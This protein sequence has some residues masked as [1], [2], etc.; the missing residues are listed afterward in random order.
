MKSKK[1]A[2][3]PGRITRPDQAWAAAY[4]EKA[5]REVSTPEASDSPVAIGTALATVDEA[6]RALAAPSVLSIDAPRRE[7]PGLALPLKF[8]TAALITAAS[9]DIRYYLNGV[10]IHAADGEMR[11][12]G[13]DGHRMI[14]S[15]FVPE[16]KLPAWTEDGIILARDELAQA[17]PVLQ[18]NGEEHQGAGSRDKTAG[19]V[20]LD[21]V[22]DA[23]AARLTCAN[24]FGSFRVTPVPGKYPDYVRVLGDAGASLARGEGDAMRTAAIAVK[25][26][27]GAADIGTKL[28]AT[29]INSF[30]GGEDVAAMFTFE[31]A[32]DTVLVV[33]P[34]RTGS[35]QVSD[36]VV[37]MLGVNG[38]AGSVAALRAHLTRTTKLLADTKNADDRERLQARRTS[39]EERIAHLIEVTGDAPPPS[40]V[41]RLA[42]RRAA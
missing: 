8:L 6:D 40:K 10:F 26:I 13:T 19:V 7:M 11:I 32:P 30:V 28:G 41:K 3:A 12:V 36:G 4:R 24:G 34:V 18:K 39:F 31:G 37:K 27:K 17:L 15:R 16:G 14:V 35:D 33:M 2:K 42:D 20:L 23:P 38:V 1:V 21:Y 9:K 29:A 25:Y 5:E 22:K